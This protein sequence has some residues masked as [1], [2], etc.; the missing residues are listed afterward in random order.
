MVIHRFIPDEA[1]CMGST[2]PDVVAEHTRTVPEDEVCVYE[3]FASTGVDISGEDGR[4]G[5]WKIGGR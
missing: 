2:D 1:L 4:E 5:A 3:G